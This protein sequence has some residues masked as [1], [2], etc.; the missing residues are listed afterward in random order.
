MFYTGTNRAE[1]GRVQRVGLATSADLLTW[2]RHGDK[3]LLEADPR[4]Y[5]ILAEGVWHEQAWRDPWVF[6]DPATGTFHAMIT[7]RLGRGPSPSR[8]V[9]AHATSADLLQ[10]TVHPP[11]TGPGPFVH[12]EIPQVATVDG[13]TFLIFSAPAGTGLPV[14]GTHALRSGHAT[15]PYDWSTHHIVDADATGS[16]YGGRLVAT[17]TGW[18]LLTWLGPGPDGVFRGELAEPVAVT[19]SAGHLRAGGG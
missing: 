9:V 18:Q 5:E 10:W 7:A 4:W 14:Q 16:R 2:H 19:V 3:P 12:L 13:V 11:V 15:G 6:R 8:G 1:G 17:P